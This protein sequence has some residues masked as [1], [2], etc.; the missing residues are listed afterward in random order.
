MAMVLL[1][2]TG[3]DCDDTDGQGVCNDGSSDDDSID[4]DGNGGDDDSDTDIDNALT[5]SFRHHFHTL[6]SLP[7]SELCPRH[8]RT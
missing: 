2:T 3:T 4:N 1:C 5:F 8:A 6:S 7:P